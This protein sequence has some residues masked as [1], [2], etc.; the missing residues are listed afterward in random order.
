MNPY[1]QDNCCTI[2]HGDCRSMLGYINEYQTVITDPVWPNCKVELY[3]HEEPK[4]MLSEAMQAVSSK[5]IAIHLGCDSD[6]RFLEAISNNWPFFRVVWF[7]MA[8]PHYKG[9]LLY[10][11][12]VAYLFGTPPTARKG[13][14]VIP[15]KIIDASSDGKQS[16]HPCPRKIKFASWLVKWWSE[17]EDTILDPFM[18]SGTTLVA[19]KNLGRK[20]IGIEIEEKYCE[21]AVGRLRQEILP[22]VGL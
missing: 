6:P 8:R 10:G 16:A 2:Y 1:Y 14:H 15:G 13:H 19:A 22:L 12:D 17:K 20:V 11:A 5:R 3:G 4:E 21:M 7:E 18:G 9:R